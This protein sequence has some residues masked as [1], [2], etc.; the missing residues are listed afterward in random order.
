M[1]LLKYTPDKGLVF[2]EFPGKRLPRYAVLSLTWQDGNWVT[3]HDL[4]TGKGMDKTGYRIIVSFA[5]RAQRD[6]VNYFWVNNCC[7]DYSRSEEQYEAINSLFDWY[8]KAVHC[9]VY[10][11]DV[12]KLHHEIHWL[13]AF[14]KS[15]WFAQGWSL[16]ELLAPKSVQFFCKDGGWLGDKTTLG[17]EIQDVTG[18]PGD[19]LEGKSLSEFT[20]AERFS[21]AQYQHTL[22]DEDRVYCMLGI[23]NVSLIPIYGEGYDLALER[24]K[25]E[26]L[27]SLKDNELAMAFGIDKAFEISKAFEINKAFVSMQSEAQAPAIPVTSLPERLN[28]GR[29]MTAVSA[30]IDSPEELP[31]GHSLTKLHQ[32]T[33][34]LNDIRN[35]VSKPDASMDCQKVLQLM[36]D[37]YIGSIDQ[38]DQS[39]SSVRN[40]WS[41]RGSHVELNP[42]ETPPLEKGRVLGYGV[43]GAVLE[44][45]CKGI[46]LALKSVHHSRKISIDQMKEIGILRR[47]KR[48]H[49]IT[50]IGTYTQ[51]PYLGLLLWPVAQFDLA[52]VLQFIVRRNFDLESQGADEEDDAKLDAY[53]E[54][55]GV[56]DRRIW[57][58]FG[59]LTSAVLY[60]HENKIRHK[61]LKPSNVLL[62]KNCV[63]ITDFGASKDFTS[64]FTSTSASAERGTL[65]YCAPEVAMYEKSGR[66]AD[67]FS[68]GCVFLEMMVVLGG[69]HTL[70]DLEACCPA[71]NRSY[72]ANLQH[73][74]N[75]LALVGGSDVQ[76]QHILYEIRQMLHSD[77]TRRPTAEAVDSRMSGI[78]QYTRSQ[79]R[80]R[81]RG[82]C[83]LR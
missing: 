20:V 62:S 76:V 7:I 2:A 74:D 41:G 78:D 81:L 79:T 16:N 15:Q 68:L 21:W 4:L 75:W 73:V 26:V 63:W 3:F 29:T 5:Q 44:V 43:S 8:Q 1:R 36:Q 83:C 69:K 35:F 82:E 32:Q 59:C 30:S 38:S 28:H 66:S 65:K 6:A 56:Q 40:D 22:R 34:I 25:L 24:L 12:S 57:S 37:D 49:V 80:R 47:L 45:T 52:M 58:I 39:L 50:L 64:D 19:A 53:E 14:K 60:L 13:E 27:R 11:S 51:R 23:F 42:G 33:K 61:D 9:Y 70:A 18:I 54:V 77:R 31:Q 46:K 67:I 55:V 48:R 10:L 72:E 71:R 17:R